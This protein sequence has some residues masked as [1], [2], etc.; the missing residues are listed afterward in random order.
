MGSVAVVDLTHAPPTARPAPAAVLRG[1]IYGRR[2][3]R[4]AWGAAATPAAR[5]QSISC[6]ATS[7]RRSSSRGPPS[8]P[9]RTCRCPTSS[10]STRS[11]STTR[12][13]QS[14]AGATRLGKG[15][16]GKERQHDCVCARCETHLRGSKGRAHLWRYF[17]NLRSPSKWASTVHQQGNQTEVDRFRQTAWLL[18]VRFFTY[19][20][21]ARARRPPWPP[22]ATQSQEINQQPLFDR[23]IV[24]Y[25]N[26]LPIFVTTLSFHIAKGVQCKAP[27]KRCRPQPR[28]RPIRSNQVQ[29]P[30]VSEAG[31]AG[32]AL[33]GRR[34]GV[35]FAQP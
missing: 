18:V 2:Q 8:T 35:R 7:R 28:R 26:P 5:S 19:A 12:A 9:T 22:S 14:T 15:K 6:T 30:C 33:I 25:P 24:S 3:P 27:P 1:Q 21:V 13:R 4:A 31:R 34:R 20:H 32:G 16:T 10:S 23:L 17:R 11:R 29:R